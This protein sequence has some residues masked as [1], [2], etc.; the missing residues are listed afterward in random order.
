[1]HFPRRTRPSF[2]SGLASPSELKAKALS[3]GVIKL[4]GHGAATIIRVLYLII[5]AR[6]LSPRDFGLVAMATVITGLFDLFTSAGLSW[7]AIQKNDITERQISQL[8]WINILVGAV[9]A[10]ICASSAP[11]IAAFYREPR[12]IWIVIVLAP[13]FLLNAAGVQHAAL[14]Q[15]DLRFATV[16]AIDV[17]SQTGGAALG[18]VM[19]L[20]GFEYWALICT[21]LV[22]PLIYTTGCW[23]STAW[24][25]GRPRWGG[26]IGELVSFGGILT[27]N[28]L[29]VYVGYN[30]EKAL[31]GRFWGSDVLGLYTRAMQLATLP[32]NS[33]NSAVGVVVFSALSRLQHDPAR[34]RSTYLS[35][36]ALVIAV[37]VPITFYFAIYADEIINVVLGSSWAEAGLMFRLMAP[38]VLVLG[39]INP[40]GWLLLA[41]GMQ[42]RSLQLGLV[43][44]PLVMCGYIVGLSYGPKGVAF[45]YSA[46]MVLWAG[47]HVI[48]ALRGTPVT[49]KDLAKVIIGP[50]LAGLLGAL[51]AIETSAVVV[52][53]Y[54]PA[55]RLGFGGLCFL[56]V[57]LPGLFLINEYRPFL[58][59]T[60][61]MLRGSK[62]LNIS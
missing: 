10:L 40:L 26:D 15:R 1:M 2:A 60:L 12:L 61:G 37:I 44:A 22:S 5:M 32:I 57:Y 3:G 43:I 4:A 6:C 19:A 8:F 42:K 16:T 53:G 47:P 27:L 48:W 50:V 14:L 38:T 25:P 49:P 18:V 59:G 29:V 33:I 51:C 24:R 9:L 52:E 54:G 13:G 36:Y 39:I 17:V 56:L 35:A 21:L 41:L 45:C 11:V 46:V 55:A 7:A 34:L 30:L 62:A 28:G 20:L 31:L 23:A 58:G